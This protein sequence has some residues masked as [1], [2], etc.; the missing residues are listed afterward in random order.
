MNDM[1]KNII[2]YGPPGTGKTYLLQKMMS[3]YID[4]QISDEQIRQA[5][6]QYSETWC[7]ITMIMLQH[8]GKMLATEIQQKIDALQLNAPISAVPSLEAHAVTPLIEGMVREPPYVFLDYGHGYWY[9]DR[10]RIQHAMPDFYN[11]F[12]SQSDVDRRYAFVTFHQSFSYEDFVEGIRPEYVKETNHIDYSPKPGVFKL[13]CTKALE[14]PEKQYA[15]FIDEINR[16]NIAE[17]FGELISLIELDKRKGMANELEVTLPYSKETFVIPNNVNIFG[18]MNS[19]DKSI[20]TIDIALRRRFDFQAMNPDERVLAQELRMNDI[21]VEDIDGINLLALFQTMNRR[22][23]ILIDR[24]HLLGHAL[25]LKVRTGDD[26]ITV[27]QHKVI[28]LLEEYFFHDLQKIQLV[29][30]D[31]TED[32]LLRDDAV[33]CSET[34]AVDRYF[35]Y[36]GDYVLEDKNH[37]FINPDL[38]A[39][40]LI[41]VY[42]NQS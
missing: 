3:D 7:L 14:H 22:I 35:D 25:F 8:H 23:E 38:Q 39:R 18:T 6:F 20:G 34:I 13:L 11:R 42:R 27:I 4:Y 16:G 28:P 41:H 29:F 24:N 40:D 21:D 33:Y 2:F 30:N 9:M 31:L 12:L 37:Y 5:F 32:G 1:A 36:S 15:I 10:I 26:I 19:A 17:I